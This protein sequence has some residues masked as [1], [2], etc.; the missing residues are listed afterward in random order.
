[1]HHSRFTAERLA[2]ERRET[3]SVCVPALN[4]A[5]TIEP[6]VRDLVDLMARGAIDQVLV[7]DGGSTD[8]TAELARRAGAEVRP[9]AQLA[10]EYGPVL[11]K[12]DAMWRALTAMHGDIVVFVDGDSGEFGPHFA[13]GLAGP[14]LFEPGVEYVKGYYRRP[15]KVGDVTLPEGG[16][17]VTELTAR[18]LLELFFPELAAIRQPLAGE[19]AARRDLLTRLAFTTGYGV[20]IAL[21]IDI[22]REVGID[23]IAEVDLDVRQNRHQPIQALGQMAGAVARAVLARAGV[24]GIHGTGLVR[25][26][27]QSL[28]IP[29]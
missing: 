14:L 15:F 19:M 21:L 3:V 25:P 10:P 5:E 17:R 18:P 4:E 27:R 8:G 7:V 24:R 11:G 20:E 6:I 2:A 28:R 12:G 23:A 29:A 9:Q 22:Y 16:G 1:V 13:C 26:P